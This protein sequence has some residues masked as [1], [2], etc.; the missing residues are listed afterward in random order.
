MRSSRNDASNVFVFI[1]TII[2]VLVNSAVVI[3]VIV[4][5][6]PSSPFPTAMHIGSLKQ[7]GMQSTIKVF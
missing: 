2:I 7:H 4:I 6:V 5:V 3:S 1:I